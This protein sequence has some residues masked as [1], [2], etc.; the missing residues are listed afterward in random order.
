MFSF[1]LCDK[2]L[3]LQERADAEMEEIDSPEHA[4]AIAEEAMDT[5][6]NDSQENQVIGESIVQWNAKG[7]LNF[8]IISKLFK[9]Y[10]QLL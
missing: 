2:I 9:E 10:L 5:S 3:I 4:L 8:Y 1:S 6:I 7:N